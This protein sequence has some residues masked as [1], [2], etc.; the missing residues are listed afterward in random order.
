[1]IQQNSKTVEA[2]IKTKFALTESLGRWKP[3]S[4]QFVKW[5]AEGAVKNSIFSVEYSAT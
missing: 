2:E 1:M 3:D 5:P 4:M